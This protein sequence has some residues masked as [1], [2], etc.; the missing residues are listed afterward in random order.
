MAESVPFMRRVL[1]SV[2]FTCQI[3]S[4]LQTF[5]GCQVRN[6]SAFGRDCRAPTFHP[7]A[8]RPKP[9]A[10]PNPACCAGATF[11]VAG[12][13]YVSA[14]FSPGTRSVTRH[15]APVPAASDRPRFKASCRSGALRAVWHEARFGKS[16][17]GN[18]KLA[19]QG[20]DHHA[21]DPAL[22]PTAPI[23]EPL[24]QCT[25]GLMA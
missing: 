17:E 22:R 23:I 12:P 5:P 4:V 7:V 10:N 6:V 9:F 15:P 19:R 14:S 2:S 18:H 25:V 1:S 20:H 16:P 13:F 8:L 21:T 24:A 3:M 11:R